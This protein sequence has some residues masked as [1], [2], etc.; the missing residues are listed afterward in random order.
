MTASWA[1]AGTA[2]SD[3]SA[4]P[5]FAVPAGMVADQVAVAVFFVNGSTD[6][7]VAPPDGTWDAAEGSPVAAS[8]HRLYIFLHRAAG[9]ESGTYTFTLDGADFVEG[10]VH[11]Y[12][13]CAT[14]GALLDA[15]TDTAVDNVGSVTTPAVDITTLGADRRLLHAASDW[16]GGTWTASVVPAF[17]KRQQP[18]VG[19]STLSDAVQAVAGG[20]G[21]V[22]AVSTN[23]DKLTAWLGALKPVAAAEVTGVAAG[24]LGGLAGSAGGTPTVLGV[25]GKQLDALTGAASGTPTVLGVA[26]GLLGALVGTASGSRTPILV[27]GTAAGTLGALVG[28]ARQQEASTVPQGNW[29]GLLDIVNEARAMALEDAGRPPSACPNDGEPL[30]EGP[31]GVLYCPYDGWTPR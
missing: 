14:S 5:A 26:T 6:R 17:T 24:S 23:L 27:T 13:D 25:A 12:T 22:S 10:Q 2:F 18:A 15:G 31:G 8:N 3:T 11:R 20:S 4:T 9:D 29:Y 19:L 28:V 7:N 1:A 30:R 16:A 21:S